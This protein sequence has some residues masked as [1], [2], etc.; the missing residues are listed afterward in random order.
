MINAAVESAAVILKT[1][2]HFN[3]RRF[4]VGSE[5]DEFTFRVAI[6]DQTIERPDAGDG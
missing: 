5:C 3:H 6:P 2:G 4:D 1:G